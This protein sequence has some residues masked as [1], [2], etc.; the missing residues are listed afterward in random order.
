MA[1]VLYK[2]GETCRVK[3]SKIQAH[4]DNGWSLENPANEI[5]KA[6]KKRGPKKKTKSEE[7]SETVAEE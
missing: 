6:P 3:P 1:T 5:E 2:D 4:L 7:T